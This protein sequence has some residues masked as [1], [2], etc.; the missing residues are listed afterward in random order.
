VL[1]NGVVRV[2]GIVES[3]RNRIVDGDRERDCDYHPFVACA[4]RFGKEKER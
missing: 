1:A 2:G 4:R 3:G